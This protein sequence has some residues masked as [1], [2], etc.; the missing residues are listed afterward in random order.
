LIECKEVE[1]SSSFSHKGESCISNKESKTSYKSKNS[2]NI[3]VKNKKNNEKVPSGEETSSINTNINTIALEDEIRIGLKNVITPNEFVNAVRT[4]YEL[5]ISNGPICEENMYG[6]IFIIEEIKISK[7]EK[8]SEEIK[9]E[10]IAQHAG[11]EDILNKDNSS[12]KAVD[13]EF[14]EINIEKDKT[15]ISNNPLVI[16]NNSEG[17]S[18]N[19]KEIILAENPNEAGLNNQNVIENIQSNLTKEELVLDSNSIGSYKYGIYGPFMGQIIGTV[20]DCCKRA[21]LN[22]DPRLFEALYLCTFQIKQENVGKVHSVLNKRRGMIINESSNDES[23]ICTIEAVIPVAE[24]F[25]FVEEIRKK[26]SG[27]ANPMLQF[28]K[29]EMIDID[30]FYLPIDQEVIDNFGVN[31]DT[32]NLAKNYVNKIRLRKG[33]PID[34]KIV[35]SSDKQKNLS[36]K[37]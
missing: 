24:S 3:S 18:L 10:N 1:D 27:M 8:T 32:P 15:L 13:E 33:L 14:L 2:K 25:G 34:E 12:K 36:K 31:I 29:W 17:K 30:P 16:D 4:G 7:D 22:G 11:N 21:F 5:A 20:K 26:S 37:R 9:S 23:I 6:V 28:H 35:K 19:D